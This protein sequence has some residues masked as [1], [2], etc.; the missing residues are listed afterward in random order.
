VLDAARN[1]RRTQYQGDWPKRSKAAITAWRQA[2]G[3]ICPGWER[4]AHPIHPADWTCDHDVGPLCRPCNG[5][6]GGGFDRRR[7]TS[8]GSG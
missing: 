4:S 5:R 7:S 8:K 1:A 3:D 6:K 2:N